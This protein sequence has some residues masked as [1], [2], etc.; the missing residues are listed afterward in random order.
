MKYDKDKDGF[1]SREE[2]RFYC[3]TLNGEYLRDLGLDMA[4]YKICGHRRGFDLNDFYNYYI[5]QTINDIE[6]TYSDLFK[7][8]SKETL[9]E[10]LR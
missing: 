7:Q 1:L 6:E 10:R 4:L 8:Y 3:T 5:D 2:F 9:K